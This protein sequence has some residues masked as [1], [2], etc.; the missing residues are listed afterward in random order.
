MRFPYLLFSIKIN[1]KYVC[2]YPYILQ[3]IYSIALYVLNTAEVTS[4]RFSFIVLN[5]FQRPTQFYYLELLN[6]CYPPLFAV[7]LCVYNLWNVWS[8]N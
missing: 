4:F 5:S 7:L 1:V 6:C 3:F 8:S 2:N